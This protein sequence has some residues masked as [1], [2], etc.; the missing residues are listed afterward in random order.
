M[1][2][3]RAGWVIPCTPIFFDY[4]VN[5]AYLCDEFQGYVP[6]QDGFRLLVADVTIKNT[7]QESIPMFDSDF[8]VQWN[9][10]AEDAYDVPI[11]YYT[12]AVSDQQLP[13][14]YDLAVDEERS[15]LL[16]FEVPEGN[17]DFSISYLEIFEDGSEADV[18]F[19]FFTAE[20]NGDSSDL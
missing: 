11:T 4:T 14:E 20:E 19:V 2:T 1:A 5:S 3:V 17:K 13:G 15:G 18:F 16:V 8:Q 10:D 7:F 9:S 12:D 6:S